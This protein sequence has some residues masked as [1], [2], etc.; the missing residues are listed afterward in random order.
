MFGGKQKKLQRRVASFLVD[1]I[2]YGKLGELFIEYYSSTHGNKIKKLVATG[3]KT[4]Y[5]LPFE[6]FAV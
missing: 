1:R 3:E 4:T 2:P 5:P 6:E